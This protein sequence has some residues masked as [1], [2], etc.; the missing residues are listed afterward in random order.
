MRAW[1]PLE[2]FLTT[3]EYFLAAALPVT[4]GFV[5]SSYLSN[6]TAILEQPDGPQA[7][8]LQRVCQA[9]AFQRSRSEAG[10]EPSIEAFLRYRLL[11]LVVIRVSHEKR[12]SLLAIRR[13]TL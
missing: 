7:S 8:L 10:R 1:D 12:S 5:T 6:L 11:D 3:F 2:A 13:L 9:P 4:F